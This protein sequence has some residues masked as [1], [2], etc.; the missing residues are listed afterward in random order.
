MA[1]C[2]LLFWPHC[3][4]SRHVQM[5]NA[6]SLHYIWAQAV[7]PVGRK[8]K[9]KKRNNYHYVLQW[10]RCRRTLN[11][12][13][14]DVWRDLYLSHKGDFQ[15]R[16]SPMEMEILD[17]KFLDWFPCVKRSQSRSWNSIQIRSIKK[18]PCDTGL[19]ETVYRTQIIREWNW[20]A[21]YMHALSWEDLQLARHPTFVGSL[22]G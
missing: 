9:K 12:D 11:R 18:Y 17:H 20:N 10:F 2:C 3:V 22:H 13:R 8:K 7:P 15:S 5:S 1:P 19:Y 14:S 21:Y 4:M 16:M 6:L